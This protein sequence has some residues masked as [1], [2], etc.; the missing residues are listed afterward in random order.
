[1]S[2]MNVSQALRAVSELKNRV[3]KHREHAQASVTHDTLTQP[4]FDFDEE[5]RGSLAATER[6]LA[7][8]TAIALAN[9]TAKVW[10]RGKTIS[11]AHAVRQLEEW[12]GQLKWLDEIEGSLLDR[13]EVTSIRYETREVNGDYKSVSVPVVNVCK[14]PKAE[15]YKLHETL[16]ADFRE[17]NDIVET[18]NHVT[19]IVVEF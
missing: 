18:S 8:Q 19:P 15:R 5:M 3:K 2:K 17:L 16:Q 12:K 10:W 6:L 13:A 11:V 7:L 14:L 1:M 4:A 9:A